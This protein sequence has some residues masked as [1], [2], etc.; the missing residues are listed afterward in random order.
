MS[1]SHT[2]TTDSPV[3]TAE[4]VIALIRRMRVVK[5]LPSAVYLSLPAELQLLAIDGHCECKRKGCEGS[6]HNAKWD[7]LG[8]P[9]AVDST[10]WTLHAPEWRHNKKCIA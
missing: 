3:Y 8:I 2:D 5:V 6:T 9:T 4:Q 1:N 7:T 10:A